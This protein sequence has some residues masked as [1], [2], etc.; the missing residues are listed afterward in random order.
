MSVL[1]ANRIHTSPPVRP[2][3][4]VGNS[5]VRQGADPNPSPLERGP[6]DRQAGPS[7]RTFGA[8]DRSHLS[9]LH[10]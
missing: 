5:R 4:P 3:G 7:C 9:F 8:P 10:A 6:K 2:E 1:L